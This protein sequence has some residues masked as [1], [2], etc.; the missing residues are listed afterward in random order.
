[1]EHIIMEPDAV[2]TPSPK[3]FF[4]WEIQSSR[5]HFLIP[6]LKMYRFLN[7]I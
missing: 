3:I 4:S 2:E 6:L 7:N 5:V 1:M